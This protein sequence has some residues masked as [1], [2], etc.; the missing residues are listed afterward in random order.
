MLAQLAKQMATAMR[1]SSGNGDDPFAK[2]K[3]LITDMIASLEKESEADASHKAY[4]DKE[5]AYANEKKADKTAE[6]QKLATKIDS[7]SGKSAKLKEEVAELQQS[8]HALAKAQAEMDKLRGEENADFTANKAD[9]E[10]GLKGVK[11]ALQV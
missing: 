10:Q 7:M 1:F 5:L 4:C 2:V 9:M 11:L 3:G 8:L 6:I